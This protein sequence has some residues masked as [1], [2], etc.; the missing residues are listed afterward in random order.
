MQTKKSHL[1]FHI[2]LKNN[3]WHKQQYLGFVQKAKNEVVVDIGSYHNSVG[4]DTGQV[5]LGVLS[6]FS[7]RLLRTKQ[8]KFTV[9][10]LLRPRISIVS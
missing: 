10:Q 1:H 9:I 6:D 8:L 2:T 7:T 4:R 3:I 5:A